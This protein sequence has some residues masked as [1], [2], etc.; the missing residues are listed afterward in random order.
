MSLLLII[1]TIFA[2]TG[3]V[4]HLLEPIDVDKNLSSE[5]AK[6]ESLSSLNGEASYEEALDSYLNAVGEM[7]ADTMKNLSPYLN[8]YGPI[9]GDIS[10]EEL[11]AEL[12]SLRDEG[13]VC[14]VKDYKISNVTAGS[15][16]DIQTAN[17]R[18]NLKGA[19]ED[20]VFLY[21]T[22]TTLYKPSHD[23]DIEEETSKQKA[24]MFKIYDRWF[25]DS[26][27]MLN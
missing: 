3:C 2:L 17:E 27:I 20:V 6:K 8:D 1:I 14:T 16:E 15:K 9:F 7:D 22:M 12:S 24:T 11:D 19:V 23:Y 13:Y 10:Q 4:G 5:I 18:E 26:M 21:I 25:L